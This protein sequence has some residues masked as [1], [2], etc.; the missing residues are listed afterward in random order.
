MDTWIM[1]TQSDVLENPEELTRAGA[2]APHSKMLG[3]ETG[4]GSGSCMAPFSST[5][6]P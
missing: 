2:S 1:L 5:Q 4:V 6:A 3:K